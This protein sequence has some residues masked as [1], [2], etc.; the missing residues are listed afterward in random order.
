MK[1]RI[2]STRLW[3]FVLAACAILAASSA[4]AQTR[5]AKPPASLRLY[6]FDGGSLNIP[7]TSPYQ[8]KKEDLASSVMSAPCFL[9][10]HPRVNL[11]WDACV[12][13]D[14]SF[15]PGGPG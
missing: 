8:L 2:H 11:M 14:G 15:K 9:V 7:D 6:V 4:I 5:A 10:S 12:V 13:P 1:I 3:T